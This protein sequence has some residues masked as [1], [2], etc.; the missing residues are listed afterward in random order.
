[1][2]LR[3]IQTRVLARLA[4]LRVRRADAAEQ[5]VFLIEHGLTSEEREA[6]VGATRRDL[7]TAGPTERWY[8]NARYVPLLVVASEV[9]YRYRG[10]GTDYWPVLEREVGCTFGPADRTEVQR[11]FASLEEATGVRPPDTPW[12]R[13]FCIIT[14]PITHAVLPMEL[15]SRLAH[16]VRDTSTPVD[17]DSPTGPLLETLLRWAREREA[18]RLVHFLEQGEVAA[19]IVRRLLQPEGAPATLSE[20]LLARIERDLRTNEEASRTLR[21]ARRRQSRLRRDARGRR[22]GQRVGPHAV[23][24]SERTEAELWLDVSDAADGDV[25]LLARPPQIAAELESKALPRLRAY[26]V[27]L[28]V[29]G[30]RRTVSCSDVVAGR[31]FEVPWAALPRQPQDGGAVPLF[32]DVEAV[33]EVDE[34]VAEHVAGIVVDLGR[35][36]LFGPQRAEDSHLRRGTPRRGATDGDWWAVLDSAAAATLPASARPRSSAS[37]WAVYSLGPPTPAW[38][39]ALGQWGSRQDR[40]DVSVDLL[41][42]P[43]I[44]G[45]RA[46]R[47]CFL[48]GDVVGLHVSGGP[49]RLGADEAPELGHDLALLR[50]PAGGGAWELPVFLDQAQI[51]A[52]A[53]ASAVSLTSASPVRLHLLG[54]SLSTRSLAQ[55]ELSVSLDADVP[56][57]GVSLTLTLRDGSGVV[58]TTTATVDGPLPARV[59]H[60][61]SAWLPISAAAA[62]R[63]HH[64]LSLEAAAGAVASSTWELEPAMAGAWWA[65]DRPGLAETDEGLAPILAYEA[66]RPAELRP[67]ESVGPGA[68]WLLQPIDEAPGLPMVGTGRCQGPRVAS[69]AA[70][71]PGRPNRLLRRLHVPNASPPAEVDATRLV[72]AYLAWR[73]AAGEGTV[74][75]AVRARVAAFMERWVVECLCGANW[76]RQEA[77]LGRGQHEAFGELAALE[78]ESR[79]LGTDEYAE[80]ALDRCPDADALRSLRRRSLVVLLEERRAVLLGDVGG[81]G[82]ASGDADPLDAACNE[83]YEEAYR[84]ARVPAGEFEEPDV[85]CDPDQARHALRAARDRWEFGRELRPLAALVHPRSRSGGL[86]NL[87]FEGL[88]HGDVVEALQDWLRR[89]PRSIVRWDLAAVESLYTLFARPA[90]PVPEGGYAPALEA[91]LVDR[92]GARAVRYAAVRRTRRLVVAGPLDDA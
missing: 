13:T 19:A 16:A 48:A 56:L 45:T 62:L 49:V 41:G 1:L 50:L 67:A 83:A 2:D 37:G 80:K 76:A 55:G 22:R 74:P 36:L 87:N 10:T 20:G 28:P 17:A 33:R 90:N 59:G 60:D 57:E 64:V 24:T 73:T 79:E 35:R 81:G 88:P 69:L 29:F 75:E 43:E 53:G 31:M 82:G 5:R 92:M 12:S 86:R 4:E 9:G 72:A 65:D 30:G 8:W 63:Q 78:L 32:P 58:A 34:R 11:R 47:A 40:P 71:Q 68:F 66:T 42:A 84:F 61:H 18:N 26:R 21:V 85:Y 54:P 46:A 70:V 77:R 44:D 39:D 27:R 89:R 6:L 25:R 38:M 15:H 3:E 14:W 51:G 23:S 52:V 91:A 7:G